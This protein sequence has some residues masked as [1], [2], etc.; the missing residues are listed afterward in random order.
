[1]QTLP[2]D[3]DLATLIT[4]HLLRGAHLAGG[5]LIV[6]GSTVVI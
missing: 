5:V 2:T 6:R 1:M 3:S 4:G